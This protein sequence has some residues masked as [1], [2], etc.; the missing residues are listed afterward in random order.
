MDLIYFDSSAVRNS[1]VF[2]T[3]TSY[4]WEM[5]FKDACDGEDVIDDL[6]LLIDCGSN[7]QLTSCSV[8]TWTLTLITWQ[9]RLWVFSHNFGLSYFRNQIRIAYFCLDRV[10]LRV[11]IFNIPRAAEWLYDSLQ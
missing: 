5:R 9:R 10:H 2:V 11:N 4:Q 6:V 1:I 7:N 3:F 8:W